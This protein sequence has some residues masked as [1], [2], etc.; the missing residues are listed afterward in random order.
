[1]NGYFCNPC[2]MHYYASECPY[3][4]AY[5]ISFQCPWCQNMFEGNVYMSGN[6]GMGHM[7]YCG[8]GENPCANISPAG[9]GYDNL[10]P[11]SDNTHPNTGHMLHDNMSPY[12]NK[13]GYISP[14]ENIYSPCDNNRMY[15][16][17]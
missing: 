5:H 8:Y 7:Q 3:R 9:Y 12:Y 16:Q 17:E 14:E 4:E 15:N 6:M 13:L 1:M 10:Y 11:E 2:R